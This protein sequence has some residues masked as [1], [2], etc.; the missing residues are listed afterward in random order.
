MELNPNETMPGTF[1]ANEQ[2]MFAGVE[3]KL[4]P[5]GERQRDIFDFT[6]GLV[7]AKKENA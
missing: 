1:A 3:G 4:T 7:E 2:E 6:T 5:E